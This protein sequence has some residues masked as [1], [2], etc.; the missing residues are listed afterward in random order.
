MHSTGARAAP[1][2]S[3]INAPDPRPIPPEPPL[4]TDCCGSGCALC[5][6]EAYAEER[7]RYEA[8]L[9]EW[10]ARRPRTGGDDAAE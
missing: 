1:M 9:A 5:V 8:R 7:G 2:D 6:N 4:P 3:S 10:R